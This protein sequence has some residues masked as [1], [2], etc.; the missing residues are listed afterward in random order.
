[1]AGRF[2]HQLVDP[3]YPVLN[4]SRRHYPVVMH[5]L[6]RHGFDGHN[7][8]SSAFVY[9]QHLGHHSGAVGDDVIW[10]NYHERFAIHRLFGGQHSM[11]QPQRLF[12]NDERYLGQIG[13]LPDFFGEQCG[14]GIGQS[15][16][17]LRL[18]LEVGGDGLLASGGDHYDPFDPRLR[19]FLHHVLK[20]GFVQD[21][22]EF[23][24]HRFGYGQKPGTQT[25]SGN[26]GGPYSHGVL[27]KGHNS[28][29][30]QC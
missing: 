3:M 29:I 10:Q 27:L 12:L 16:F 14:S 24:G 21:G 25:G 28:N 4:W 5:P 8:A 13:G 23:L 20:H 7:T 17:Q 18:S 11:S 30:G 22:Q 9:L 6:P 26:N 15:G 19:S 1:M 2:L